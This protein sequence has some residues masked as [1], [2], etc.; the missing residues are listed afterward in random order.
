[1]PP[2]HGFLSPS[3]LGNLT[4]TYTPT[5]GYSGADSFTFK[6]NDVKVDCSIATVTINLIDP[7][8]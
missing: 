7:S 4:R 6:A 3:N 2:S 8:K 1:M 5:V